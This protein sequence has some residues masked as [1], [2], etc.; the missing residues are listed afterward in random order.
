M[1]RMVNVASVDLPT[2]NLETISSSIKSRSLGIIFM[3]L[4]FPKNANSLR[5]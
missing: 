4:M 1:V 3:T 5:I 2:A